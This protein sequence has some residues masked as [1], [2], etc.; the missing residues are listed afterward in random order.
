MLT[1]SFDLMFECVL[2]LSKLIWAKIS[3][4]T[5]WLNSEEEKALVEFHK[6]QY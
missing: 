3:H 1:R 6:M 4:L 2:I 5:C